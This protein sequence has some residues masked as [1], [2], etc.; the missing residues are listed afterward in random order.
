MSQLDQLIPSIKDYFPGKPLS[1]AKGDAFILDVHGNKGEY[2]IQY[3]KGGLREQATDSVI[4]EER[5]S[6]EILY[7][8]KELKE[9]ESHKKDRILEMSK[10]R[11][12]RVGGCRAFCQNLRGSTL[13]VNALVVGQNVKKG[14]AYRRGS[15]KANAIKGGSGCYIF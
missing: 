5:D 3:S 9:I 15:I 11:R 2:T 12:Q 14:K 13:V 10:Q 4:L 7:D 1:T 6:D 8:E